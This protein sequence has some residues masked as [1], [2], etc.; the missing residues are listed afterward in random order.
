MSQ[1]KGTSTF[2]VQR[3]SA[4]LLLPLVLWF[5]ISVVT[6]AGDSYDEMRA[7]LSDPLA[8]LP[9][10]AFVIIGAVHMR[11][12]MAE[13]IVDYIHSWMKSVLLLMNWLV[14]IG[15]IAASLFALFQLSFAG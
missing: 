10:A 7:W 4:A 12:G 2:V 3:A 5:L 6:H 11:I 14:A 15:V 8:A 13:I 1:H 9:L